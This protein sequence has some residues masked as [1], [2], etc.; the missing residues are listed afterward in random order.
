MGGGAGVILAAQPPGLAHR[1]AALLLAAVGGEQAA[2]SLLGQVVVTFPQLA[3]MRSGEGGRHP[4]IG[5]MGGGGRGS[6]RGGR[7]RGGIEEAWLSCKRRNGENVRLSKGS[8]ILS[9]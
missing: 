6:G 9:G 8:F 2:R 5:M 3:G 4:H 7:D 1:A